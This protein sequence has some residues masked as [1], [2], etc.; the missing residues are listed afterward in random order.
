V[1]QR[2]Q[3]T[4]PDEMFEEL[5]ETKGEFVVSQICQ[6][7]LEAEIRRIKLLKKGTSNM[8]AVVERLRSE[9]KELAGQY[10]DQGYENG[11][12]EAKTLHLST[13]RSIHEIADTESEDSILGSVLHYL[14]EEGV[15]QKDSDFF[16]ER[17]PDDWKSNEFDEDAYVLGWARGVHD[18]YEEVKDQI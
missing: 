12:E 16:E 6:G 8:N 18:F 15:T 13:L 2:I 5:K 1:S 14:R 3:I 4:V 17:C 11:L 9:K 10:K 7:A